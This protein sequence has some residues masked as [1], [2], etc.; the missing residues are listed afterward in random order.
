MQ[1]YFLIF[2]FFSFA[3]NLMSSE[4]YLKEIEKKMEIVCASMQET[5]CKKIRERW[6]NI[7]NKLWQ[8]YER[9]EQE[10]IVNNMAQVIMTQLHR[11]HGQNLSNYSQKGE[12]LATQPVLKKKVGRT[13]KL[14]LTSRF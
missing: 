4:N 1:K 10:I 8:E 13:K 11:G 5:E 12:R 7:Y 3:K 2:M 6:K 9:V 14:A